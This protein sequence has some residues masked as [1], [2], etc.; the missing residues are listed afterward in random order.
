MV[1]A[2]ERRGGNRRHKETTSSKKYNLGKKI[3]Y[4][5][6]TTSVASIILK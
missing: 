4:K 6:K 1:N 5:K 2:C 3:E